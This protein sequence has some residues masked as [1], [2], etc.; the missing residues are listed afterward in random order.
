MTEAEC[1]IANAIKKGGVTD[2]TSQAISNY[3]SNIVL[4]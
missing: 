3:G 1:K 2:T 4:L